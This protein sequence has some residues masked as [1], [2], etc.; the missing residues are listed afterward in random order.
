MPC[1][2]ICECILHANNSRDIREDRVSGL[3][4]LATLLGFARSYFVFAGLILASFATVAAMAFAEGRVSMLLVLLAVPMVCPARRRP[5]RARPRLN[6]RR[7]RAPQALRVISRFSKDVDVMAGEQQPL[8][9]PSPPAG[10]RP[11]WRQRRRRA[12]AAL[13]PRRRRVSRRPTRG[14]RRAR[15]ALQP[16][17]LRARAAWRGLKRGPEC[18]PPAQD[19][20]AAHGLRG[21]AHCRR[22][23]VVTGR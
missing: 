22:A 20:G 13:P 9:P 2:F 1:A 8:H 19:G 12:A 17:P 7:G 3:T 21:A 16:A 5:P 6:A 10:G 4:T 14:L 11:A 18:R 23:A 15:A